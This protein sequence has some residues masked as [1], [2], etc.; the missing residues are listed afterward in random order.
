MAFLLLLAFVDAYDLRVIF[1]VIMVNNIIAYVK[2]C[3]IYKGEILFTMA[4]LTVHQLEGSSKAHYLYM[5]VT[6]WAFSI[7]GK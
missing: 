2:I 4:V 1:Q 7:T 3:K 6:S 5:Y